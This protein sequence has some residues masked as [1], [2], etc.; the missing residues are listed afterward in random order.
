MSNQSECDSQE[1]A[2]AIALLEEAKFIIDTML[3]REGLISVG[4]SIRKRLNEATDSTS[5]AVVVLNWT[6][7]EI[8]EES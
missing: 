8:E 1:L 4:P 7:D 5:N 3:D 6:L 2:R